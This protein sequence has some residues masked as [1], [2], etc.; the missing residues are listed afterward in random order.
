MFKASP[1]VGSVIILACVLNV[2]VCES[3]F[4]IRSSHV[5]LTVKKGAAETVATIAILRT[6]EKGNRSDAVVV[7]ATSS[8]SFSAGSCG[9]NT[10][11][12]ISRSSFWLA[13]TSCDPLEMSP[14]F[15]YHGAIATATR[16][17]TAHSVGSRFFST[18][19][20][21]ETARLPITPRLLWL[22]TKGKALSKFYAR[23]SK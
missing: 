8:L 21:P 15:F 16:V 9:A 1:M 5:L 2:C 13:R 7:T 20:A 23:R 17:F 6:L 4:R 12:S 10:A 3:V 18:F 22:A 11:C 19:Q 14:I